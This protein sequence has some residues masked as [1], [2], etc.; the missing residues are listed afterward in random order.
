MCLSLRSQSRPHLH[1][2]LFLS[3]YIRSL[4]HQRMRCFE[5]QPL[6]STVLPTTDSPG[7]IADSDP[8]E[9]EE[10]LKE[11]PKEDPTDYPT[12]GGDDDD[13]DDSSDD[14]EDDDDD[15]VE[16]DED[17]EEEHPAPADFVLPSV[18]LVMAR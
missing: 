4:C 11:D 17:E 3:L 16:E 13:D 6:P 9:D 5:E 7:Y 1:H 2:S 18:H 12:D 14:D 15:D 8:K 10:D